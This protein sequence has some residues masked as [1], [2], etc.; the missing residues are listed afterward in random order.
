VLELELILIR[1][2]LRQA[3]R[4]VSPNHSNLLPLAVMMSWPRF[5]VRLTLYQAQA[6]VLAVTVYWLRRLRLLR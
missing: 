1:L 5:P 6:V 2:S 4:L 3:V